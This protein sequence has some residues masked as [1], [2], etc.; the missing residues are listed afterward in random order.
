VRQKLKEKHTVYV[1]HWPEIRV[2]K[3]GYSERRR[4]R[5]FLSRGAEIVDLVEFEDVSDAFAYEDVLHDALR[6]NGY[7]FDTAL[8]AK[9]YLGGAGGGYMECFRM[10]DGKTPWQILCAVDWMAL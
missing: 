4:W 10:P 5:A 6:P 9:P 2:V 1:V 7:A 3:A 8:E